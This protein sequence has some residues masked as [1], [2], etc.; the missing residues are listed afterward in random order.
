MPVDKR[1]F[2]ICELI[3]TEKNY[4][5]ALNMIKNNFIVPL[6]KYLSEDEKKYIFFGIEVDNGLILNPWCVDNDVLFLFIIFFFFDEQKLHE[7]HSGFHCDLIRACSHTNGLK[8]HMVFTNW[9]EKFL[10]YGDLC[11]NLPSAQRTIEMVTAKSKQVAEVLEVISQFNPIPSSLNC[12]EINRKIGF[13]RIVS[14]RL[15][16]V[17]F[18]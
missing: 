4:I 14:A 12:N 2:S 10:L 18:S 13:R 5:D 11:S 15:V 16:V 1:D 8:L 17:H 7:I 3:E 9:K 6:S